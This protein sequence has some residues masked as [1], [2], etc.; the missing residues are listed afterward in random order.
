MSCKCMAGGSG[1]NDSSSHAVA[2]RVPS[3]AA[4]SYEVQC[5]ACLC[6]RSS[7]ASNMSVVIILARTLEHP[8]PSII[9][10][11]ALQQK[12]TLFRSK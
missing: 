7:S 9:V 10:Y 4:G 8:T 1:L 6:S 5:Q 12:Q 11:V 2:Q 3:A